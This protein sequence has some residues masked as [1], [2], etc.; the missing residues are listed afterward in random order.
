MIDVVFTVHAI[1]QMKERLISKI[2]VLTSIKRADKVIG[3]QDG[4][5]QYI[6]LFKENR[7]SFLLVA[8][9]E[10]STRKLTIVTVFKTSKIKKYL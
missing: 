8:I 9:I 1:Q 2:F 10:K 4:R 5:F 6:K 3:Q 7:K